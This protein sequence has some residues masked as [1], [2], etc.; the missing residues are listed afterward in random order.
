MSIFEIIV[1]YS[2]SWWLMLL[3]VLPLSSQPSPTPELGHAVSAPENPGLRRKFR[4]ATLLAV[5]QVVL[6]YFLIHS[7]LFALGS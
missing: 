1:V 2:V 6:A 7:T 4:L 5:I 3:L